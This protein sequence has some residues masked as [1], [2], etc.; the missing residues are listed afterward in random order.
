[1]RAIPNLSCASLPR[2]LPAILFVLTQIFTAAPEI[3]AQEVTVKLAPVQTKV[4]FTLGATM[5]TVHGS[6]QLKSG[7]I[8]FDTTSGKADGRIVVD[9][10]SGESGDSSRDARMEKEVLESGKYPEIIF[11]PS[12]L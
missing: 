4:E 2:H 10:T 5:H 8:T 1:V 7:S 12:Q 6:F 11:I 3:N 9:A